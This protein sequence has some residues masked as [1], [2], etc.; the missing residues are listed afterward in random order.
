MTPLELNMLLHC[1][2]H[3]DPLPLPSDV[4][5]QALE[6]F[7]KDGFVKATATK[8]CYVTDE[9]GHAYVQ[10]LMSIPYPQKTW[11]VPGMP[12]MFPVAA[13][14]TPTGDAR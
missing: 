12:L 10:A 14:A 2:A 7:I 6:W 13:L 11:H 1:Y 5:K 4:H 9:R 8:G 3:A